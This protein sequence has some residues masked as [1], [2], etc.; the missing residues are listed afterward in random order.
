MRPLIAFAFSVFLLSAQAETPPMSCNVFDYTFCFRKDR[1]DMVTHRSGPDF[2]IYN[3]STRDDV[4]LFSI[5][6]GMAP[7]RQP[8]RLSLKQYRNDGVDIDI[9]VVTTPSG[10]KVA[11]VLVGL[12]RGE[13]VH[14][15]GA[16]DRQGREALAEVMPNF[17]HCKK[18]WFTSVDCENGSLFKPA[19][20]DLIRKI[21]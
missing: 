21:E 17:R 19:D 4:P 11:D 15:F 14:V 6:A 3:V 20:A 5:Y 2:D 10:T 16:V 13:Y 9:G 7:S 8:G 1:S 12:P 18:R